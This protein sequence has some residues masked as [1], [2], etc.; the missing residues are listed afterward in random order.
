MLFDEVIGQEQPKALFRQMI[1]TDRMPHALLLLAATGSGGLPLALALAQ[2]LLCE[3]S[4]EQDSAC[5]E[6]KHCRKAAKY[7][8][9][10]LHFSFPTIGTNALSDHFLPQWRE[11]LFANP[12]L[13]INDWLQHIGAENKQGNINKDECLNIIRKLS[14]KSFESPRKVVIL[15]LPEYLGNE[16]NRLL[17]VIEEPP[18]QTV[19][20]LVAENQE[21]I[22]NTILSRCQLVKINLLSDEEIATAL[23]ERNGLPAED[24][25]AIAQ[26]ASGNFNDAL[27]AAQHEESDQAVQFLD[28]MRRCYK[29]LPKEMV[30]WANDFA[31][32]GRENQ[33]HFLQYALHF[34]R[35]FLVLKTRGEEVVRLREREKQT[36]IGMAKVIQLPQL[37]AIIQLLDDCMFYVERNAH[38]KIL[39][40]DASIQINHI[41]KHWSAYQEQ[42]KA[43]LA[44]GLA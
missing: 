16:G 14:L 12:Y 22:L 13:E 30:E 44:K 6:C 15:W 1:H 8:H 27:K 5:G 36:A 31:G 29:G 40:L 23:R 4:G 17:K 21:L 39:F 2:Y 32:Q 18:E 43:R 34:W 35:E 9:P 11:A 25:M 28:W 41:I 7:V 20:I 37:E 10:D 38:P 33:K 26:L 24:A 19:F 42:Q 3:Q